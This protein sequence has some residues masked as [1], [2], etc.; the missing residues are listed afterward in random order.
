MEEEIGWSEP[1][2]PMTR[3]DRAADIK[4][5]ACP[6]R[7]RA[8]ISSRAMR[9]TCRRPTRADTR[10]SWPAEGRRRGRRGRQPLPRLRRRHRRQRHRALASRG[11]EGHR[12]SGA[13][14]P[15]H[16]GH[17]LLLR[18]AGAA[19]PR[20]CRR[21]RPWTA[22]VRS[23]FGNS[24]TEAVEA[25]LKLAKW[26]TKRHNVIAFLGV[27]PRPDD[28]VAVA[29][30]EQAAPAEGLRPDGAGRVPRALREL[31][32]VSG[33]P[34]GRHVLRRMRERH[35]GSAVRAPRVARRGRR[36]DRRADP[37]RGR[38]RRPAAGVPRAA[39]RADRAARN[40]A[41]RRRSAVR[42]GAHGEDVRHRALRRGARHRGH[43][44]GHRV[45]D[46]AWRL[47][48]RAPR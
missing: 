40:P 18:A 45:G 11:G 34:Q 14:L 1:D 35:R 19:R 23:F 22:P 2:E 38:V 8:P 27:V 9:G 21:L 7:R 29:D 41:R 30:V 33:R 16:V 36:R 12:G 24:G 48:R 10:S 4:T 32:S 46:A 44:E 13:A 3:H 25:A 47:R 31:L 26:Y 42:H 20:R 28:G 6:A 5:A 39:A 15:P 37:G 43:G 17:R